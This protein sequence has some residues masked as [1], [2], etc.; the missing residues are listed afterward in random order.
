MHL[1]DAQ[2]SPVARQGREAHSGDDAALL[3]DLRWYA[4][5]L[6]SRFEFAV[7]DALHA[8]GIEEFLPTYTTE[9]RA[10]GRTQLTTRPLFAGYIFAKFS[11][12]G[13]S[14][15]VLRTRGVA[16]ILGAAGV[17]TAIPDGEIANLQRMAAKSVSVSRCSYV[18]GETVQIARG[19]FAGVIGEVTRTQGAVRLTVAIPILGRA[20]SVAI[21]VADLD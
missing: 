16:G 13:A 9:T 19:P 10:P 3:S 6:R 15:D 8:A 17:P 12:A 11:A 20:V 14:N 5:R 7:R 4:L 2:A 18:A 1:T 21:D